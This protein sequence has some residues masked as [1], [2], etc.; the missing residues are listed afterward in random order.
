MSKEL[1]KAV[2]ILLIQ[3]ENEH[4]SEFSEEPIEKVKLELEKLKI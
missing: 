1:I 4:L 2:E 3:L